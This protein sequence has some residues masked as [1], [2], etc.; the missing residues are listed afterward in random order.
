MT[1]VDKGTC[2]DD[3]INIE[4]CHY[5]FDLSHAFTRIINQFVWLV[6]GDWVLICYEK[7]ILLAGG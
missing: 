7:T 4:I 1:I 6:A 3:F 2:D 5:E